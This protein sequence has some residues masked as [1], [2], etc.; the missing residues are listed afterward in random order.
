MFIQRTVRS[1]KRDSPVERNIGFFNGSVLRGIFIYFNE[2][3]SSVTQECFR[4]DERMILKAVFQRW[5][6]GFGIRKVLI[7]IR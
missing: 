1:R 4:T 3:E 7:L 2:I 5:N 6:E